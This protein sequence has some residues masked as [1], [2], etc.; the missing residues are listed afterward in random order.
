MRTQEN[1]VTSY[2]KLVQAINKLSINDK[3]KLFK[4]LKRERI[5]MNLDKIREL[6]Q[7]F[8]ISFTELTKEVESVRKNCYDNMKKN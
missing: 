1:T 6:T 8:S 7:D 4:K 2:N 3:E 5:K